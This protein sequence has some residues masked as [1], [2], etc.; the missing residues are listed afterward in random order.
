MTEKRRE[1]LI[2]DV[3]RICHYAYIYNHLQLDCIYITF[4]LHLYILHSYDIYIELFYTSSGSFI[5]MGR[6]HP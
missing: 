6:Y 1:S 4:T 2:G 3:D 5:P